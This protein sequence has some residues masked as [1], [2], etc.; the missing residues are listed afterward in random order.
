MESGND[1]LGKKAELR[2][3]EWLDNPAQGYSFDRIPDQMTGYYA[4]SR[5]ICDFIC[6]KYPTQFYI[7]S[8]STWKDRFDFSMISDFQYQG[9]LSKSQIEGCRGYVIILFASYKR[10]FIVDIRDIDYL[11]T[12]KNRKSLNIKKLNSW[13]I[14]YQEIPTIPSRKEILNYCGE[15]DMLDSMLQTTRL[16]S[17]DN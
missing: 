15:L 8:K 10:A 7:E 13:N 1:G 9:L 4:V 2:I 14:P 17:K 16:C 3:K 5:N 12:A 6:Y 11:K